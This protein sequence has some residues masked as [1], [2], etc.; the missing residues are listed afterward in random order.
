[1]KI[2]IPCSPCFPCTAATLY[3]YSVPHFESR[4]LACP[5]RQ[6]VYETT[7]ELVTVT[8]KN[9]C[10]IIKC[11]FD[12]VRVGSIP[13]LPKGTVTVDTCYTFEAILTARV[14]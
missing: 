10:C 1:M 11:H 13:M 7:K 14:G 2:Q 9:H 4:G 5:S 6:A 8:I 3:S 12:G